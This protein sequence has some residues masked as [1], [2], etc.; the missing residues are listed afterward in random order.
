M[1]A[2]RPITC[3]YQDISFTHQVCIQLLCDD[4]LG[5]TLGYKGEQ[6]QAWFPSGNIKSPMGKALID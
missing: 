6:K 2:K 3:L 1:A 5:Q 4:R